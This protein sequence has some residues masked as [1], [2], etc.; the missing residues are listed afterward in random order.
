MV[1]ECAQRPFTS[2]IDEV[3]KCFYFALPCRREREI[4]YHIDPSIINAQI[5]KYHEK[6]HASL[7]TPRPSLAAMA[8]PA[9]AILSLQANQKLAEYDFTAVTTPGYKDGAT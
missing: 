6:Y 5:A 1:E 2:Q 7:T 3:G 8:R 4:K 9:R